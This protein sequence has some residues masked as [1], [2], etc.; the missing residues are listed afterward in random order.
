MRARIAAIL[1]ALALA[2]GIGAISAAPASAHTSTCAH[3][4]HHSGHDNAYEIR[5]RGHFL[6][7]NGQHVHEYAYYRRA[8]WWG[9]YDFVYNY[10][11]WG[12]CS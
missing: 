10:Q 2:L 6:A 7:S 1:T 12:T 3:S 9:R 4:S 5:Y 8:T 11:R